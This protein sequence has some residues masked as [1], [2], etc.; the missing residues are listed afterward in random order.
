MVFER[1]DTFGEMLHADMLCS[2]CESLGDSAKLKEGYTTRP[3]KNNAMGKDKV[4][5]NDLPRL[6]C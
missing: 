1:I 5:T 2:Q 6:I 3:K 4:Q